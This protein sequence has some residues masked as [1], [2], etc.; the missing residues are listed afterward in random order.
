M[1]RF[2]LQR[3]IF[4]ATFALAAALATVLVLAMRWN[5]VQGFERYT[6]TAEL[7]R[8]DWLVASIESAYAEQGNWEF[9]RAD[10]QGA[11]QRLQRRARPDETDGGRMPPPPAQRRRPPAD[12]PGS[13]GWTPPGD[14]LGIGPRLSLADASGAHLAG[15]SGSSP[16]I[17]SRPIRHAGISIGHL[18]LR[19]TPAAASEL[20]Q[21][22]LASQTH[23]MLLA[24]AAALGLSLLAAWLLSR[25]LLT[26]IRDLAAG[27]S[28]IAGGDL[29]V[30]IPVR[31][32]DELGELAHA[33]NTMA[34]QL[35]AQETTRRTWISESSHELRTPLAV[36][37]AEIEALQD[38]VRAP[39]DATL[40]RLHK[41]VRQLTMLVDDLRR[42]LEH[43]PGE[44]AMALGTLSP[45][46]LLLETV[47]GFRE[48]YRTAD[49][50]LDTDGLAHPDATLR[51]DAGRLTQVYANLLEN[52]LRYTHV[53]G[54]VCLTS[55]IEDARLI[56][57]FDD[58]P[59]APPE[60]SLPLLFER[61]YRAEAS[62][63]RALGGSGLGLAICK[64]IIEAHGGAIG[65]T[66]SP[67]GGLSVRIA[68]PLET[69]S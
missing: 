57:Q 12:G 66:L 28:A 2:P 5:L 45:I 58:T 30:R 26:P 18:N 43:A 13:P 32:G 56:V 54:R 11:W 16:T 14:P 19:A 47:A 10:P 50:A 40:A 36:L 24:A 35:A 21:A 49:I 17:A 53:G 33:F 55:R 7:A 20:D 64:A 34:T 48:R 6:A 22:F 15:V 65:A 51:G 25:H 68:L 3:K 29:D 59:P 60:A 44:G 39:D 63:S 23:T 37:R 52:S 69:M 46:E 1:T 31:G 41:Q 27:A 8:L 9:M 62:R 67:L 61:F 4:L 42:T 38:G